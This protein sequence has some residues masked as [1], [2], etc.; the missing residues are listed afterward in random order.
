[1]NALTRK[2]WRDLWHI[3]TQASAIALVVAVGI[4]NLVMSQATLVSLRDSRDR[5][6]DENAFADLF[7]A[8]ERAPLALAAD[9][10]AI[11][12]VRT[13]ETRIVA[14]GSGELPWFDDPVQVQALSLPEQGA[15]RLNR[16]RLLAGRAPLS[17][18]TRTL[19][20]SDAFAEAHALRPGDAL[21]L[22]LRGR[23]QQFRI[24]GIGG[25]PEFVAQMQ[26]G[27][28]FPDFERFAV[29]WMPRRALEAAMDLDG[30]FN[31][32]ALALDPRAQPRAVLTAVDRLLHRY[33]GTGAL[34]RADQISHRYLSEELRQLATMA[35]LF[36][37]VFLG[38]AAFV[39]HVVLGRLVA[40]QREQIA[41]L[42]AFGYG[43]E[44]I[45]RH[46]AGFALIIAAVG[47]VLGLALGSWLGQ[48][49]AGVYRTFYRLPFLDFSIPTGTALLALLV[50]AVAALAGA[51]N[52]LLRAARLPP[53]EA[54]RPEVPWGQRLTRVDRSRWFHR[55]SQ[56][57]RLI[58]RNLLRRPLRSILTVVGLSA[59]CA[60]MMMG[61]F[62]GDAIDLI[63]GHQFRESRRHDISV[64][65]I[66]P[67]GRAALHELAALPGVL[68][69]EAERAVAV[70]VRH[71]N[72]EQRIALQALLPGSLLRRPLDSS[73]ARIDAP[74]AG[75]LVTDFLA[76][77]LDAR[78]GDLLEF[79][80]LEGRQRTL[81]LPLAG[82]VS[83]YFGVTAY[84]P[85]D[86]LNRLLGDGD[87][88]TGALL[89]VDAARRAEV[90]DALER[91]PRIASIGQ[92]EVGIR[93]F[94]ESM[95]ETL[96]T[97]TLIATLFGAVI[98]FGVVYN[99]ARVTL[100]ERARDLASLRV[101]GFTENEVSYILLGEI[102]VLTLLA[103]PLGFVAGNLLVAAMVSGFDSDL[104]RIPHYV[105]ERTY[106]LAGLSMLAAAIASGFVVWRRVAALDMIGVLK[107]RE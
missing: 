41:V 54:M 27:A 71:R 40:G 90:I 38:V 101:L 11:P 16:M 34:L 28:F 93:N 105:S 9:L 30:A 86:T 107:A 87:V 23:R 75:V 102:A 61:R 56:P 84:L 1:M 63:V 68:R 31:S 7:V 69:V 6:Y 50:A 91:R 60:V 79:V 3:R 48:L 26:P 99:S 15:G 80:S 70:V 96:L 100:S 44:E 106:A 73:G 39:L 12:G 78:P 18:E 66:E 4:A 29:V 92:R 82:T 19:A 10:A 81:T 51:G 13:V 20:I 97:F 42:K 53:A 46:Y 67:T 43:R 17:G 33:G 57:S 104:F 24:V 25:S 62:Q 83:E 47:S 36:P 55:L 88:I 103:V 58:V 2:L 65:F 95:G 49:L 64:A 77:M 35:R 8:L 14:F 72:R 52:A 74:A 76:G 32:A 89:T 85:L 59:G 94:Y 37:M 5:Y 45:F 21:T 98:T 22:V